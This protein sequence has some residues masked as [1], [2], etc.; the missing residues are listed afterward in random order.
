MRQISVC[1]A[2]YNG[3]T[4]IADQLR[5][6]LGQLSDSDE[7]IVSDDGSTDATI[8]VVK[9]LNDPRIHIFSHPG[10]GS[11]VSNFEHALTKAKGDFIFLSDQ[12]DIW[13]P[14]KLEVMLRLLEN[15][16]LVVSD[17]SIIDKNG[18]I[19]NPSFFDIRKSGKGILKNIKAN[20]YM[21]SCMGFKSHILEKALPF[22]E[23]IPMHDWWIGMTAE[24]S[25]DILFCREK[26][27]K[28]RL[29]DHNLSSFASGKKK[30]FKQRFVFRKNIVIPLALKWIKSRYSGI[31]Q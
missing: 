11:P 1:M 27:V 6:I 21:G 3:E 19:I 31:L 2:A 10:P 4:F 7:I 12:D 8:E 5:S 28:Y 17:C 18:S 30:G 14:D 16:D 13:E 25:G 23:N 24:M 20:T 15:Y 29:H 22:P 26:L 9:G